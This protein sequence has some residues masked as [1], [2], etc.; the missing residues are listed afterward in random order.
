ML[1]A[2]PSAAQWVN[3]PTD[4]LPKKSDGAFNPDAPPPVGI[5]GKPDFSG[6]W[7]PAFGPFND[8]SQSI[9]GLD[10]VPLTEEGRA[11]R[12]SRNDGQN[13]LSE[14]DQYCLPQGVPKI[15]QAPV[16]WR[17]VQT[18]KLMVNVYEAFNLWRQ[19]HIDSRQFAD[20]LNP[21]WLGHSLGHWEGDTL[22][23]ESRGFNGRTWLDTGGLPSSD[24]LKV[25]ERYSRPTYGR[26]EI[27]YTIDDPVYYTEP[28]DATV[29]LTLYPDTELI[30]FICQENERDSRHI[31]AVQGPKQ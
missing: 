2:I 27:A 21:T 13:R 25:I 10:K 15:N 24:Q 28:W 31:E 1:L 4:D 29:S 11:L 30:E 7:Q 17:I 5:D 9:G 18:P 23:V 6:I 22:V 12:L 26:L 16:P 19:I 8:L 14:P 20:D 3:I